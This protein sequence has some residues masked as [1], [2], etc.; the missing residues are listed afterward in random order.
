MIIVSTLV[1]ALGGLALLCT[2]ACALATVTTR[3]GRDAHAPGA[4]PEYVRLERRGQYRA[5]RPRIW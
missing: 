5:P 4:V 1:M 2:I 3:R